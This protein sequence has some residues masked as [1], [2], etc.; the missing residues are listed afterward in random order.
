MHVFT[1]GFLWRSA[2]PILKLKKKKMGCEGSKNVSMG[3]KDSNMK[4]L[5]DRNNLPLEIMSSNV[6]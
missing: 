4:L 1:E 2:V 5:T 3:G 6:P